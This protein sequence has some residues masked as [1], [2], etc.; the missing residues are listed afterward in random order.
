MGR[1]RVPDNNGRIYCSQ[2]CLEKRRA[3]MKAVGK[4]VLIE[5]EQ[6]EENGILV[7]EGNRGK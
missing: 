7:E 5:V 4:W 6:Q 1:R 2:E 3:K